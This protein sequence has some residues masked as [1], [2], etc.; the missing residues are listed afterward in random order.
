MNKEGRGCDYLRQK[1]PYISE[2]KI[3][4]GIFISPQVQQLFQELNFKNKLNA[5]DR[6]AWDRI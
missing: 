6:R 1:V 3:Q 4:E 2:A 5:A